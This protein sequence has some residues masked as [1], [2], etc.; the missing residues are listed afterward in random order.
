[1]DLEK[2]YSEVLIAEKTNNKISRIHL[3]T[4]SRRSTYLD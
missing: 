4:P 3:A 1:M 2:E